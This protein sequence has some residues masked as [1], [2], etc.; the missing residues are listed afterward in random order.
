MVIRKAYRFRLEPDEVQQALLHR[1]CGHTRFVWNKALELQ[2][3][4]LERGIPL[5]RYGDLGKYLTLWRASEEYGFL[6]Q[7]PVHTQQ[8]ALKRLD[9]ALWEGLDKRNPKG[10]PTFRKRG[11]HDSLRYPDAKQIK[12]DLSVWDEA[13]RRRWPRIF[14]PK[15]GWV[16]FRKTRAIEGT[17]KN[18][19]VTLRN[20]RW[21]VAIQVEVARSL[22]LPPLK[23][24]ALDLGVSNLITLPDGTVFDP[25]SPLRR[26]EEKLAWEQRKLSR[27][28]RFSK[29]WYKQKHRIA[30][31]H[32][33]IANIR[34]DWL[35]QL[36]TR[37][38][39]NHAILVVEDLKV[40]NMTKSAKGTLEA[41]GRNVKAKAG[42]NQ[43][44]LDQGWGMLVA[45]LQYKLAWR[46][47][48]LVKVDPKGTSR[49]CPRPGC[50][51]VAKENRI[52]RDRFRCVK[53]GFEAPADQVGAFNILSRGMERLR[54]EGRDTADASVGWL[55]ALLAGHSPDRLFADYFGEPELAPV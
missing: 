51:H 41:P 39:Q 19:T 55:K 23:I 44:I 49:T 26:F 53:C 16:K 25:V 52:S 27:K 31:L 35:Q 46:G 34:R 14:L 7:G 28:K 30:R 9:Q 43:S 29:N 6:R 10:F 54:D 50:G 33:R 20:G 37:L 36:T 17:V 3:R 13:G 24:A 40:R 38:C 1:F 21:Y 48:I 47:G 15:V 12:L 11:V 42:L 5:L 32:E 4:R 45:M 18:A 2:K 22:P 8:Q